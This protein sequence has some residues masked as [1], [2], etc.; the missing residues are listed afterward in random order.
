MAAEPKTEIYLDNAAT[1]WPKPPAVLQAMAAYQEEVGASA[2]R[3]GYRRAVRA[4]EVLF[5][6]REAVAALFG[7]RDSRRVIFTLNATAALNLALWGYLREGDHVVTTSMEHNSVARP[8]NHLKRERGVETTYVAASAEGFVDPGDVAKA[9][10]RATRLVAIIHASN[11]CGAINDVAA[12]GS[13]C[14]E[15]GIKV[16]VD[17]AQSA[18]SAPLDVE[19]MNLDL[20]AFP[21]HKG[22]LGPLG[23]GVL[24][25]GPGVDFP[26]LVQGGTGTNSELTSQPDFLPDRYEAGSH[27]AVGIAGLK[28]ACDFVAAA[29]PEAIGQHKSALAGRFARAVAEVPGVTCFGPADFSLNAGVVSIR[30]SGVDVATLGRRLDEEYGIMVRT[31]LHCAPLAHRTLGTMDTGTARFSFGYFN[32]AEHADAAARAVAAIVVGER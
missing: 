12:V 19:S 32:T 5:D 26:S 1:S 21:G 2:G 23:T 30:A 28:A 25:V 14:R 24:Y 27:N 7:V 17:A 16:L 6:A 8:L 22:L 31:G 4:A 11:V 29:T 3:G 10:T 20:A 13:L 9:I 18:G 15:R